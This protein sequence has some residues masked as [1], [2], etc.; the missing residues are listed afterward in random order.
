MQWQ[1]IHSPDEVEAVQKRSYDKPQVILKH[2]TRCNI[3]AMS[4]ARLERAY[5]DSADALDWHL[6]LVVEDRRASSHAAELFD[7]HHQS[8]QLM[9]IVNGECIFEE[10]H[11]EISLQDTLDALSEHQAA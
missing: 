10:T 11:G 4:K 7:V 5:T 6:L 3:S 1:Q 2:S 8:P 9:L